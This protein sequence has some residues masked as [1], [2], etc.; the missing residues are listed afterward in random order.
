MFVISHAKSAS[1]TLITYAE[2]VVTVKV[3]DPEAIN[4]QVETFSLASFLREIGIPFKAVR[5]ITSGE[6][7][8]AEV[9]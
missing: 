6:R 1:L 3:T 8:E 9:G 5:A 2:G 4:P 7:V